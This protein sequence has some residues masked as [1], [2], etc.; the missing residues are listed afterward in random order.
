LYTWVSPFSLRDTLGKGGLLQ[1]SDWYF[2]RRTQIRLSRA[3][4]SRP[5]TT[6]SIQIR[7]NVPPKP[8]IEVSCRMLWESGRKSTAYCADHPLFSSTLYYNWNYYLSMY[9]NEFGQEI[10]FCLT[11][12]SLELCLGER[13]NDKNYAKQFY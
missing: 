13:S 3:L 12:S 1:R 4:A 2:R 10:S 8:L 11:L 9:M 6:T 7:P 5:Q